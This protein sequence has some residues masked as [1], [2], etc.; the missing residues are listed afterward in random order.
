M[1]WMQVGSLRGPEGPQGVPGPKGD[2]GEPG[3]DGARGE[4]GPPG[5]RGEQ[6]PRG[7]RG[8]DGRGIELKG[9]VESYADLPSDLGEEA[10]GAGFLNRSDGRLYIWDGE[11]FPDDGNG[12]VFRGPQGEEGPEGPRGPQGDVGPEGPSGDRGEQG[13][14]GE[15]GEP[16]ATIYTGVGAPAG[17]SDPIPN[18]LYIDMSSGVAYRFS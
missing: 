10:A 2:P 3:I 15:P 6:G 13:P 5:E 12:V 9:G 17:I 8:E 4:Q 11:K 14:P 16:G 1:A 18:S 7:L